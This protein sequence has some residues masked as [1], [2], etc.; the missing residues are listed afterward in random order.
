M[1]AR[2]ICATIRLQKVGI[3]CIFLVESAA[4]P[5]GFPPAPDNPPG[6]RLTFY[7]H[8]VMILRGTRRHHGAA[9]CDTCGT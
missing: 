6:G 2:E 9:G 4:K 1:T 8:D 7:F 3:F 5:F